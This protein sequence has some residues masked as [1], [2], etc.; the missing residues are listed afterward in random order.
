MKRLILLIPVLCAVAAA[1]VN[2]NMSAL[3]G[4]YAVSYIGWVTMVQGTSSMTF[5]GTIVG[6]ISIGHDGK[7]SGGG[8]VAGFGPVTDYD[9]SGTVELGSDCTGTLRM[10]SKPR[11]GGTAEAEVDR[12]VFIPDDKMLFATIV[13]MGPAVYP[14]VIG[15][16]K[17]ITPVPNA[18]NW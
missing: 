4:T 11:A 16:W 12:F 7:L 8:A 17:R 18:S 13:D 5:P 2:C 6:V 10:K 14:A 9:I 15:T 3:A 1:Q